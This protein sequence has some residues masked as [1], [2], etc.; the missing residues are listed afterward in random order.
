M[1]YYEKY[2]VLLSPSKSWEFMNYEFN[3]EGIGDCISRTM[4]EARKNKLHRGVMTC[5]HLLKQRKRWPKEFNNDRIAKNKIVELWSKLWWQDFDS[6]N[7]S[8]KRWSKLTRFFGLKRETLLYRPQNNMTRD[9][10]FYFYAACVMLD[11]KHLIEFRKPPWWLFSPPLWLWR[12]YIITGKG[13]RLYLLVDRINTMF[14]P[15]DYVIK[16]INIRNELINF[17]P[18]H[19]RDKL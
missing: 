8:R 17:V 14:N 6:K 7:I 5:F 11:C 2:G 15:P 19:N 9:P 10:Y 1:S 12:R 3:P 18:L 4:D 13:K 16:M